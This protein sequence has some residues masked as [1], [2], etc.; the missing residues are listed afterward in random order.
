MIPPSHLEH[1]PQFVWPDENDASPSRGSRA[2]H[3][4]PRLYPNL[5]TPFTA[6]FRRG[7]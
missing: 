1:N 3:R 4:T 6:W 5:Y 7:A 2:M